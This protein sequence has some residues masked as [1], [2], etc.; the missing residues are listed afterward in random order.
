MKTLRIACS[1]L[2]VAA[3]MSVMP[4]MAGAT[5][6]VSS[7]V[8]VWKPMVMKPFSTVTKYYNFNF[9]YSPYHSL[10]ISL[11][12]DDSD[13]HLI[14]GSIL[15]NTPGV[16]MQEETVHTVTPNSPYYVSSV[17]F[18]FRGY[19]NV[20]GNRTSYWIEG[21]WYKDPSGNDHWAITRNTY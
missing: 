15:S 21:N 10:T 6:P 2:L 20:F 14:G 3:L 17:T 5:T 1:T 19:H 12:F 9:A 11:S 8:K 7:P 13:Y 16:D 18:V 4:A